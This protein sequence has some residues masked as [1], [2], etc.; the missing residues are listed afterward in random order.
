M[1][2]DGET[3]RVEGSEL[4]AETW[5]ANPAFELG[6]VTMTR[7][8]GSYFH[9]SAVLRH[10]LMGVYGAEEAEGVIAMISDWLELD[11]A[12]SWVRHDSEIVSVLSSSPV[13]Q[14]WGGEGS[15]NIWALHMAEYNFFTR[16]CNRSCPTRHIWTYK[17]QYSHRLAIAVRLRP[18]GAPSTP[19]SH[20]P[21]TCNFP[22]DCLSMTRPSFRQPPP[23]APPLAL[24][25]TKCPHCPRLLPRHRHRFAPHWDPEPCRRQKHQRLS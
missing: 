6:E 17:L 11:A 20:G 10:L 12:D 19:A 1:S 9:E 23:R 24:R 4:R 7:L 5:R 13:P 14:N 3:R 2:S 18:M 25:V 22:S 15:H 21:L 16:P 8:G